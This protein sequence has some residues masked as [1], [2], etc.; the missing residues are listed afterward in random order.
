MKLWK[1]KSSGPIHAFQLGYSLGGLLSPK[2]AEPFIDERFSG[3]Y[4]T[5]NQSSNWCNESE[6][7]L[8]QHSADLNTS[9]TNLS[10]PLPST[11]LYP[12]KFVTAYWIIAALSMLTGIS[13]LVYYIYDNIKGMGIDVDDCKMKD[14]NNPTSYRDGF[15]L[16]SCSPKHPKLAIGIILLFS[17][18][19][20]VSVPL[21]RA[22]SKFLFSYARDFLCMTVTDS[23]TL[24]SAF[25][26]AVTIARLSA[27]LISP[28]LH[29]KYMLQVSLSFQA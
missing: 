13:F 15:R 21:I 6:V 10:S 23:S 16:R 5:S 11:P 3:G 8:I 24:N 25:F 17:L 26:I 14:D 1:E 29:V 12:A 9:S 19:Y 7:S 28:F 27:F 20:G 4:Q 18:Q 2:L 22:T